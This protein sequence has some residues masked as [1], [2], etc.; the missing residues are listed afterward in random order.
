MPRIG[1][2]HNIR[3]IAI[4]V[5]GADTRAIK[6]SA[7]RSVSETSP[8]YSRLPHTRV[9]LRGGPNKDRV[10]S[11]GFERCLRQRWQANKGHRQ[12]APKRQLTLSWS[13][14]SVDPL[15][16]TILLMQANADDRALYADYLRAFGFRVQEA[17][18]KDDALPLVQGFRSRDYGAV[19]ARL[20][21]RR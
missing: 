2:G 18:T 6:T 1:G 15:V 13:A 9:L 4:R 5:G 19:G 20:D 21:Y 3:F 12:I 10:L 11:L 8:R 17:G 14:A 7:C 16:P